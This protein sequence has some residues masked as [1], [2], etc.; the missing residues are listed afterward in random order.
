MVVTVLDYD[1]GTVNI[2][3]DLTDEEGSE[4]NIETYLSEELGFR[5]SNIEY[6]VTDA[7]SLAINPEV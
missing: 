5:I 7:L 2:Y 4:E 3:T 1:N 6:M